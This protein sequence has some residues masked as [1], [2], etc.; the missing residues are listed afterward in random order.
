MSVRYIS[1]FFCEKLYAICSDF[2][3]IPVRN[4]MPTL[5]SEHGAGVIGRCRPFYL[6]T[7]PQLPGNIITGNCLWGNTRY[8][9]SRLRLNLGPTS[10]TLGQDW[11]GVEHFQHNTHLEI[12]NLWK[13]QVMPRLW[14]GIREP[15]GSQNVDNAVASN[16]HWEICTPLWS[17]SGPQ[18]GGMLPL[19]CGWGARGILFRDS[20]EGGYWLER[21]RR[22]DP[23]C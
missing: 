10:K 21:P 5:I 4:T 2:W 6:I 20:V 17:I 19:L 13:I 11:I 23:D 7:G 1:A 14:G 16:D 18:S 12:L 15:D 3:K 8:K 9:K 22:I